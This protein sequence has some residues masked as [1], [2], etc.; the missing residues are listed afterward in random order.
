[1]KITK[2]KLTPNA[3]Q[4]MQ[5]NIDQNFFR[6]DIQPGGCNGFVYKMEI[7][8]NG[9]ES[10]YIYNIEKTKI[11][12]VSKTAEALAEFLEIDFQ[13][14]LAS[15]K[16]VFKNTKSAQS[17]SCGESFTIEDIEIFKNAK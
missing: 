13:K 14:T 12:A 16:F 9:H 8:N 1:M 5:K 17:C 15:G 10:D 4:H 6:L 3:I 2:I 11:F 7:T